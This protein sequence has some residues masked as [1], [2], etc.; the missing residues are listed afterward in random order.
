VG[1]LQL[2]WDGTVRFSNRR[3]RELVGADLSHLADLRA[4]LHDGEWAV[5]NA[6]CTAAVQSGTDDEFD[7][8]LRRPESSAALRCRVTL[9]AVA[10]SAD[11][12][13][14]LVS[15]VDITELKTQASIDPLTGVHNR[16]SIMAALQHALSRAAS[17]VGV[18]FVDL[19]SF[20]PVNDRYGHIAGD[21]VLQVVAERI[22]GAVRR[23]DEIG[24]LG[25]DEFVIVCPDLRSPD[26]LGMVAN[27]VAAD[28]AAPIVVEGDLTVTVGASLGCATG[29]AGLVTAAQ[30]V[31]E[32]DA[33][34]YVA[35]RE[36]ASRW[37]IPPEPV[38]AA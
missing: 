25:G 1:L 13:G 15:V 2:G 16:P 37:T 19:D 27:R 34:M 5:L 30:L 38:P 29:R 11:H 14:V 4:H 17:E 21:R 26:E 35:K 7:L 12:L 3:M 18:L 32:A 20:K 24:R 22:R 36:L 28:I 8:T 6:G 31:A 33:A 23:G 9:S 10:D